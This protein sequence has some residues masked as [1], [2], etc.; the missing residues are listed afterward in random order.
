[1]QLYPG[2]TAQLVPSQ[3]SPLIVLLSSQPSAVGPQETRRPSP[4]MGEQLSTPPIPEPSV[5]DEVHAK[6]SSMRQSAS[7]P[8]PPSVLWSSHCSAVERMPLPQMWT[9]ATKVTTSASGSVSFASVGA[10]STS[11]KISAA[12]ASSDASAGSKGDSPSLVIATPKLTPAGAAPGGC[13]AREADVSSLVSMA[14][15]G[16]GPMWPGL[17]I[18]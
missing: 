12:A 8:S 9:G 5:L 7:Q 11:T 14:I 15:G 18:A 6:P 3:P 16:C 4:Q 13:A 1:M 17:P 2:S 10:T